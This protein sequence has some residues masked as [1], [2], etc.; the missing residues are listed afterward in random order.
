[1]KNKLTRLSILLFIVLLT[2][3]ALVVFVNP[4]N[5]GEPHS[6]GLIGGSPTANSNSGSGQGPN[7]G[8]GLSQTPTG[9][10]SG[11]QHDGSG[12]HDDGGYNG[13]DDSGSYG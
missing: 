9:T 10:S 13:N 1:M 8:S 4:F 2:M 11:T 5:L 7:S 3:G 6:T 12:G